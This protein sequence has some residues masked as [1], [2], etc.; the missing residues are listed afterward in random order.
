MGISGIFGKA[1]KAKE[2]YDKSQEKREAVDKSLFRIGVYGHKGVG[3]TV[4]FTVAYASSKHSPD[5]EIMA[6]GETQEILEEKYNLM[7][8]Q[9]IDMG[10]GKKIAERRFPPLSTG[11]Q[12]LNFEIRVGKNKIV[13]VNSIDYSGELI[14]IDAKGDIKQNL[15]DFFKNCECVLFF[16][17]PDAI[18]NEGERSNRIAAFTD[19]IGQLSGIEKHLKIPIGLVVSKSDELRGFKSAEQSVLIGSGNGYIRALN[20]SGFLRGVLKQRKVAGRS[21]WKDEMELMLNR[22][23]SFF[24]PLLNRTLDYQ[25]FFISSTGNSPD[26]VSGSDYDK[27]KVPPEDLRPLGVTEPLKWAISRISAYR[28]AVVYKSVLKWSFLIIALIIDIM[29]F[30]H[31]YNYLKVK[32]LQRKIESTYREE[33]GA[34]SRIAGYY[35]NYSNNIIIRNFFGEYSKKAMAES[36]Y[37]SKLGNRQAQKS[38]Q[39]QIGQMMAQTESDFSSLGLFKAD[40]IRYDSARVA[41]ETKIKSVD[42]AAALLNDAGLKAEIGGRL[43]KVKL[44][45]ERAPTGGEISQTQKLSDRYDIVLANFRDNLSM[46]DY[47]YLLNKEKFPAFLKTF[48]DSLAANCTDNPQAAEYMR[49]IQNYLSSIGQFDN[50]LAI[51]FRVEGADGGESGYSIFFSGAF[52]IPAG[53]ITSNTAGV[54]IRVPIVPLEGK[55]FTLTVR[56]SGRNIDSCQIDPGY[57][58]LKLNKNIVFADPN[59]KIRLVFDLNRDFFPV[60]ANKL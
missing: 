53:D 25:V 11:E 4:F 45:L 47:D 1:G 30:G 19:L 56:Q 32:D 28:R 24:K 57:G 7:R 31:F 14:Y 43:A 27:V 8:G 41:L 20:F 16:I 49:A 38:Q 55:K 51:P 36:I 23:E 44:G 13:P 2:K 59:I 54:Q 17:D 3:K 22:L 21:D 12:R 50:G 40:T 58:I 37:Y 42:S 6:L 48:K 29:A 46:Q 39:E 26:V 5:F 52:G 60:F 33:S 34:N 35:R 9:G 18:Q 10:S 15:I